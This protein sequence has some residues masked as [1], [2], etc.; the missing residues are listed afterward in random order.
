[1]T[2][3][4]IRYERSEHIGTLTLNRPKKL[5]AQSPLMWSELRDLG[6][7]LRQDESL[8]CLVVTGAGPSFSSGIDLQEGLTGMLG[9]MTSTEPS[10]Q[11]VDLDVGQGLAGTFMWI[12]DLHCPSVA[13]VRGHAYGAGLQ[14]ALACDFRIFGRDA[15][16][17]LLETRYGLLPDMG[18]TI[19]LPRI[20]GESRAREMIL[21]GQIIDGEEACRIGLANRL[22]DAAEVD[23][24][25]AAFAAVIASKPPLSLQGARRALDV[26]WYSDPDTSLRVAL[27]EQI[28]CMRSADFKEGLSAL[29]EGRTPEWQG[30]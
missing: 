2:Y 21:L 12:P 7:A 28:R 6:A 1:V 16:V 23:A 11:G 4:T 30:R 26:A 17:G 27:T 24:A 20:I 15:K 13:A 14:L 18:A 8:R 29:A 22:V 10:S 9:G 3:E 25:A 5:N 19:R